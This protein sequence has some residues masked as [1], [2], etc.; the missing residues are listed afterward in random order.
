MRKVRQIGHESARFGK[1]LDF[2]DI[3]V[4]DRDLKVRVNGNKKSKTVTK[5]GSALGKVFQLV[6]KK[7]ES[8]VLNSHEKT[9]KVSGA[10]T[11]IAGEA[12]NDN[13]EDTFSDSVH[14][15]RVFRCV[16][17]PHEQYKRVISLCDNENEGTINYFFSN[18][19]RV[20]D[21]MC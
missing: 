13:I 3:K 16:R 4:K 10:F 15:V 2:M 14:E 21:E 12:V 19:N 9:I 7:I 6:E 1:L 20:G 5:L 8:F 18:G 17:R 11:S